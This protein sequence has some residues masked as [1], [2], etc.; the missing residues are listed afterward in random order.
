MNLKSLVARVVRRPGDSLR[1]SGA[2]W[3]NGN[4]AP[5]K[6][7]ELKI[8]DGP[9]IATRLDDEHVAP[10]AWRF[11]SYDWTNAPAGEHTLV[12]RAIDADGNVQPSADDPVIKLKKTYWEANEQLPRR[13]NL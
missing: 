6:A 9:W 13:I 4:R 11:W 3:T 7:V 12:S 2:A 1:I 8:D 5:I 10:Y